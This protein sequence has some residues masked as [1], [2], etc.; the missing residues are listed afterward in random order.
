MNKHIKIILFASLLL[1]SSFA[2]DVDTVTLQLKWK[3]QYQF[4]GFYMAKEKGYFSAAGLEVIIKEGRPGIDFVTEVVSGNAQF[5]IEMPNL[6]ISRSEGKPIQVLYPIFHHSPLII[7]SKRSSNIKTPA[8]LEGKTL[9]MNRK[10]DAQ[11]EA[12]F[13]EMHVNVSKINIVS[14]S[15]NVNDL[16]DG[17]VDAMSSYI[18]SQPF[19]LKQ[20]KLEY[21]IIDSKT[22]GID[23]FGD[24]LFSTDDYISKNKRIVNAFIAHQSRGGDM[25]F[26]I[27]MKR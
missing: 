27:Q 1:I 21:S 19:M 22:Y 7:L 10:R 17:K 16:I 11:L 6:L 25:P 2:K 12:M 5:G 24:C 20:K 14:H 9:M 23:F 15:W 26:K 13:K 4:A 3:H 8:D 18:T